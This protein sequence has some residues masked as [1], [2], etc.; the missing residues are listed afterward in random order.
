MSTRKVSTTVL[1][2]LLEGVTCF[3][4]VFIGQNWFAGEVGHIIINPN[5]YKCS[6]G[7]YGCLEGNISGT[8]IASI[9]REKIAKG[10]KS[11]LLI[12]HK[13]NEIN[14]KL[15]L[16]Y[17]HKGD[18]FSGNIINHVIDNLG[19]GLASI[20]AILNPEV[21]ILG[22]S[23]AEGLSQFYWKDILDRTSHYAIP[24]YK[25]NP[26]IKMTALGDDA[27]ILGASIIV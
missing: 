19:K 22:G 9:A 5:G 20:L 15:I 8:A 13:E 12:K 4:L 27:S 17:A 2:N 7:C 16:D 3:Y 10:E 24:F 18:K 26:P 11:N 23:V 1:R 6:I 21:I 14:S 25:K